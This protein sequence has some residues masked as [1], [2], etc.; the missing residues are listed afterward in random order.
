MPNQE[1]LNRAMFSRLSVLESEHIRHKED[2]DGFKDSLKDLT[3]ALIA[4]KDSLQVFKLF[5]VIAAFCA[6]SNPAYEVGSKLISL[7]SKL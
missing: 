7:I 4:F 6:I 2:L 5:L 1:E 3:D